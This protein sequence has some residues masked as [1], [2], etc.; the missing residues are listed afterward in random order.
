MSEALK[1][2]NP[3]RPFQVT[4]EGLKRIVLG[5][6]GEAGASVHVAH[7]DATPKPLRL[8]G[9]PTGQHLV[10]AHA[11]RGA[12]TAH[13]HEAIAAAALL[14]D[15]ATAVT[16]LV[17]GDLS[18]KLAPFGADRVIVA[19]VGD[20][21][22][23]DPD[24]E[25]A[26]AAEQVARLAPR[27]IVMPDSAIGDGD[28]GRRLAARLGVSVATHVVELA[29]TGVAAS[30][31]GGAEMARRDLPR[32]LLLDPGTTDLALPFSGAGE[33]V[34][35][36]VP[37]FP[38]SRYRDLGSPPVDSA[39]LGLEDADFIV[40]AG[41]GVADVPTLLALAKTFDAAI[42]AS[43]VAVDDGRFARHQQVGATG[44]TVSASVYMAIGISGAV[45]HLQGIRAV[46]HVIAINTDAS[47][48][49]AQRADL[50][51]VDDAQA[52]ME[53]L[54]EATRGRNFAPGVTP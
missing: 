7:R 49:I 47:A 50:T 4:A 25:L 13:A 15:A 31:R 44:K 39:Q 3:R 41:N 32:M 52:V 18:E 26:V 9:E 11:D 53:Q 21:A 27:H 51:I 2:I 48:P 16:V 5:V 38:D 8:R 12:L 20:G 35:I 34:E 37:P 43:R 40:S 33:R 14:A 30:W 23:F 24:R 29:P 36:E 42:G 17:F 22:H 10:I 19:A 6:A 45:Q 1:R 46:R 28:L 54:L